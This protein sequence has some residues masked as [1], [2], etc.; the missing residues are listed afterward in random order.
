M[1][2]TPYWHYKPKN[3][4]HADSAGVNASDRILFLTTI[5]KIH[6]KC[7]VTDGSIVNDLRQLILYTFVLSKPA[8]FRVHT[9]LKQYTTKKYICFEYYNV[10]SRRW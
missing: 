5:N 4:I 7:D 3:A 2:F 1:G 8:G 10:L 9:N 6:F